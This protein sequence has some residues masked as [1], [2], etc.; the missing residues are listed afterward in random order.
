MSNGDGEISEERLAAN[1]ILGAIDLYLEKMRDDS[2]LRR[3]VERA[4]AEGRTDI[5][6]QELKQFVSSEQRQWDRHLELVHQAAR[7]L[8]MSPPIEPE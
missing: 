5:T 8:S 4:E 2:R 3:F 1:V 6:P 7:A